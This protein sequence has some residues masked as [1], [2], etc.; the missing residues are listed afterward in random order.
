ML[1]NYNAMLEGLTE[2]PDG[3]PVIPVRPSDIAAMADRIMKIDQER[4]TALLNTLKVMNTLQPPASA[5]ALP[6]HL[7]VDELV[8]EVEN[9][10]A[11]T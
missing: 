2:H 1:R 6:A 9:V 3:S 7:D 4:V 8:V 5:P 11:E 10:A